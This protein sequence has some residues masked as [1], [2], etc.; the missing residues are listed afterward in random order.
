[1]S[2][3][4][5]INGTITSYD[6]KKGEGRIQADDGH[7]YWFSLKSLAKAEDSDYLMV[8]MEVSL[9][10]EVKDGNYTA[11]D[12]TVT[13]PEAFDDEKIRYVEPASFMCVKEDLVDGYDVLDR[14]LYP[15]ARG[16]RTEEKARYRLINE[17]TTLGANAIVRY[18]V[19]CQLKSAF[20][21]GF[22]HYT[23]KGVP[24]VL[25]KPDPQGELSANDLK[26]RL[27]QE[28]IKKNH[29]AIIN[30]KIGKLVLQALGA[31]LLFIFTLG[32]LFAR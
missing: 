27:D 23:A 7:I 11:S 9:K 22:N 32:F 14:G 25:G 12:V 21:Y 5:L 26:N 3:N 2:D 10:G 17:C 31:I 13:N 16:E 4:G 29:N 8:G 15:I 24:V 19:E 30:T 1:M 6:N 20:G 18:E 28:R